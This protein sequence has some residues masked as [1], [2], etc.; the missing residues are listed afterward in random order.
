[1]MKIERTNTK[2][3]SAT[4]MRYN[5]IPQFMCSVRVSFIK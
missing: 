2:R 4:Y 5:F 1:M 3:G